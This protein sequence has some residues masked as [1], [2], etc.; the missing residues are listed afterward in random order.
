MDTRNMVDF[1][2]DE[3]R[4]VVPR[5]RALQGRHSSNIVT[6]M[7]H[8]RQWLRLAASAVGPDVRVPKSSKMRSPTAV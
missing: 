7:D 6:R 4:I 3:Y 1:G 5:K 2:G 8:W